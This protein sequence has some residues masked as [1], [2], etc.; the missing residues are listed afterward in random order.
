MEEKK[1]KE[2]FNELKYIKDKKEYLDELIKL[3]EQILYERTWFV[4][5]YINSDLRKQ[6]FDFLKLKI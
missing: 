4:K 5:N 1:Y 3:I 2:L 6:F